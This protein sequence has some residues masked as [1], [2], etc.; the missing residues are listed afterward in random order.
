MLLTLA[1]FL[2]VL[3]VLIFVHELGHFMAAKAVGIGVPRFSIGI[4]PVT[5]LSF[6]RGE[7]EYLISWIPFGGYV[8]MASRE[9]QEAMAAL[10]G[11]SIE[12]EF[13]PEKLIE[14]KS[15]AAR[16]LVISAGVIMNALFAWVAYSGLILAYGQA[17]DPT[18]RVSRVDAETL[19]VEASALAELP[20]GTR[21]LGVNG[22]PV[23]SWNDIVDGILDPSTDRLQ[24]EFD[25]GI[26]PLVVDVPGTAAEQRTQIA[27]SL[28]PLWPPRIGSLAPSRPAAEAGMLPGD[29]ITHIDG[30]PLASWDGLVK[31][32]EDSVDQ[33]LRFTVERNGASIEL[34]IA[35]A[36]EEITDPISG[37]SR[38]VGRIGVS[39]QLETRHIKLG[40]LASLGAG[41]EQTWESGVQILGFLK[42][43][44]LGQ[45]SAQNLGGPILIGQASGQ[46]ARAGIVPL[47]TFMAFLSMNLAILNLLPI[48]VLDGG[49]LVFLIL[50]GLRGKPL[51]L[52]LRLRLTQVGM[53][54]LLAIMLFA[55]INDVL[56]IVG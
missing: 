44:V 6:R 4:G 13:P 46:F 32:V 7:T 8:K 5:P 14:T 54:V 40:L 45:V 23:D 42:G 16:I 12:Q 50:E 19:P 26:D 48:P 53:Y 28:I 22:Q 31:K 35:P 21:I 18:V 52:N 30:E 3:G 9:E 36:E 24:L 29:L 11:G 10:E 47:I 51:P 25:G 20:A 34:E 37:E 33:A 39:P 55:V 2:L 38:R 49:H 15:L 41:A 56:R 43:M 17:E 27:R 1:A